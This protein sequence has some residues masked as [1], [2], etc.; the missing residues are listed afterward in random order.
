M[1]PPSTISA[2]IYIHLH[3][4]LYFSVAVLE[5]TPS[6]YQSIPF[7]A[8]H[9]IPTFSCLSNFFARQTKYA[10]RSTLK[11][12]FPHRIFAMEIFHSLSMWWG[13][14]RQVVPLACQIVKK[15]GTATFVT[16]PFSSPHCLH[17]RFYLLKG[18]CPLRTPVATI[19]AKSV[20]T[21]P[22]RNNPKIHSLRVRCYHFFRMVAPFWQALQEPHSPA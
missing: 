5:D 13:W 21:T 16:L 22:R 14:Y 18:L 8:R 2:F 1:K 17:H 7:P 12:Y 9:I 19:P 3:I 6:S 10:F 11:T 20:A 4:F 15:N